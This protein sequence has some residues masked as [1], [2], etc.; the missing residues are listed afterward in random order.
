MAH[1]NSGMLDR[2][3]FMAGVG[4]PLGALALWQGA[5]KVLAEPDGAGAAGAGPLIERTLGRTGIKVPVVG[6]GV[7]NASLPALVVESYKRGV[8][9]FDTAWFYQRGLNESMVGDMVQQLGCRDKVVIATKI[10]LKE[11]RRDLYTPA[12]K[13]LFLERFAQSLER[14][15][16]SYVDILY[17]HAASEVR[18]IQN[19]PILEAFEELKKAGKIRFR[20]VSFHGDQAAM[21]ADMTRSGFYDVGLVLFNAAMGDNVAGGNEQRLLSAFEAAAKSGIG[22][23]AMKTQCGGGGEWATRSQGQG[24]IQDLNH[25][26]LLKWVLTHPFITAAI[27]GYTTFAQMETD[28]A[29][30]HDLEYTAAEKAFLER[31]RIRL[32]QSFCDQCGVCRGQCPQ[33]VDVP[34]LM[35]THMYAYGY[36]NLELALAT[37]GTIAPKAGAERCQECTQCSVRCPRRLDVP[38]RLARVHSIASAY[39]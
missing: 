19:P 26:A 5:P 36:R 32:A 21:L 27:P 31:E 22:L 16:T 9:L 35:R 7:M 3:G 1:K 33:G 25:P 23:V 11:T 38:G 29:V 37:H 13:S 12:I 8:R 18:E 17:Y 39:A 10:F 20:G 15:K 34:T 24:Q 6:M 30:A 2:R 28:V 4:G 14:L